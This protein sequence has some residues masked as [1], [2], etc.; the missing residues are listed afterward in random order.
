MPEL[1]PQVEVV[2]VLA[3]VAAPV[4]R[5]LQVSPVDVVSSEM[6]LPAVLVLGQRCLMVAWESSIHLTEIEH[7]ATA[8][9]LKIE[10]SEGEPQDELVG[11]VA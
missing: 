5:V 6:V 2:A 1:E 4:T 10:R 11:P 8:E 7:F 9:Q 3:V